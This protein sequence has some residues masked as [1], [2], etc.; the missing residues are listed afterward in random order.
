MN[1][2]ILKYFRS[3]Y[4]ARP[5][6][7]LLIRS[8]GLCELCNRLVLLSYMNMHIWNLHDFMHAHI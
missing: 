1:R 5:K 4:I 2:T 6:Y 7:V 3:F 8:Y